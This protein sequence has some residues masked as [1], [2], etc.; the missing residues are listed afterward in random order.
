[1][2]CGH[3]V[4]G[5]G[6]G[7]GPGLCTGRDALGRSTGGERFGSRSLGGVENGLLM[8]STAALARGLG[9]PLRELEMF[10]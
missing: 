8:R 7:S 2:G 3:S 5:A 4:Q 6:A 10:R 1:M 9:C